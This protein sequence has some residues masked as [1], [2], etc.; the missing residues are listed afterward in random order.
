[1]LE[2]KS[3]NSGGLK[4]KKICDKST[5]RISGRLVFPIRE[6]ARAIILYGGELIRTAR[7]TKVFEQS[8][9]IAHFETERYVYRVSLVP[10]ANVAQTKKE[11]AKCA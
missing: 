1:M 4:A 10:H 2:H 9:Y 11:Y 7:V 6:G 5:I 8:E 3:I